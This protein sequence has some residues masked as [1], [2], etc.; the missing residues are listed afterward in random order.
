MEYILFFKKTNVSFGFKSAIN[1]LQICLKFMNISQN[2]RHVKINGC[3]VHVF[4]ESPV[5][6]R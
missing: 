5:L 4:A 3:K 2:K 6:S 1:F